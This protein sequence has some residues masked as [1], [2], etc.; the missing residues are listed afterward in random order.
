MTDRNAV[1]MHYSIED[2]LQRIEKGLH[3][4]GIAIDSVTV[5]DLSLIDEF[6]IGGRKA[7]EHFFPQIGFK[8][9]D[10]VLDIGSGIGGGSR[11]AASKFGV[12]VEGVDLTESFV[13]AG[14]ELN[15]WVGIE[16]M[17]SLRVGD[18]T[19]LAFQDEEFDAAFSMHVS[20]N[21]KDKEAVFKE[22]YRVLRPGGAFG[23]YDPM[24]LG[25]G[26]L[27]FP[28]PWAADDSTSFLASSGEYVSILEKSGFIVEDV[29]N[30]HE[31]GVRFFQDVAEKLASAG[32]P[33]PLGIHIHMGDDA[34]EKVTNLSANLAQGLVAPFEIIARKP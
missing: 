4:A 5:D 34:R 12:R 1:A 22:V 31:F 9:G 33:P 18:A 23:V 19:R 24:R 10:R 17:V 13:A 28:V 14:I 20:M 32:G 21:I 8:A 26:E 16:N 7:T 29:T 6:H 25:D 27:A 30:R 2:I 3:A 11:F 15:K